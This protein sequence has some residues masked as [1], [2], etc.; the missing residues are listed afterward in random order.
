MMK[1]K[2]RI[3]TDV[4]YIIDTTDH[5]MAKRKLLD[6]LAVDGYENSE[7]TECTTTTITEPDINFDDL[8]TD[9][10]TP[11]YMYGEIGLRL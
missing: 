5:T 2:A 8:D 10:C 11:C 4:E 6:R 7:I 3:L 9:F 1:V